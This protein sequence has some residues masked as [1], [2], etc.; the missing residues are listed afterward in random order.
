MGTIGDEDQMDVPPK[1]VI[2]G[3]ISEKRLGKDPSAAMLSVASLGQKSKISEITAS[4]VKNNFM[5]VEKDR[6]MSNPLKKVG[7]SAG[8]LLKDTSGAIL[9]DAGAFERAHS[10]Q[11]TINE[12]SAIKNSNENL[13]G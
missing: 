5:K 4:K 8:M 7:L 2:S 3:K 10:R 6:F 1:S 13:R 11:L 9:E 12:Y